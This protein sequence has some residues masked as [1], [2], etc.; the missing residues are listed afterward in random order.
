[1]DKA[2]LYKSRDNEHINCIKIEKHASYT[3]RRVSL[4]FLI[5]MTS[6][7]DISTLKLHLAAIEQEISKLEGM[8]HD[9]GKNNSDCND[10]DD[11]DVYSEDSPW[12]RYLSK[13]FTKLNEF[14]RD[15]AQCERMLRKHGVS[16]PSRDEY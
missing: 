3:T 7:E 8:V 9:V 16:V 6:I 15:R 12:A 11:D 14:S 5:C 2:T 4:I 1:M 10:S 13:L